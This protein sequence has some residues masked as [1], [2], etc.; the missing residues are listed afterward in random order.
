M[1]PSRHTPTQSMLRLPAASAAV[2]A[3]AASATSESTC[4]T[5]SLGGRFHIAS[6]LGI[7]G[8][9]TYVA[10]SILNRPENASGRRSSPGNPQHGSPVVI[11]LKEE[12]VHGQRTHSE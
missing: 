6:S 7:A 2:I 11:Q 12:P 5:V 4:R 3:C 9:G 10:G 1:Q 8:G